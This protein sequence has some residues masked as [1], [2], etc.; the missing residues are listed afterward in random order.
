MRSI[1][2]ARWYSSLQ[3]N[4]VQKSPFAFV[5]STGTWQGQLAGEGGGLFGDPV[6]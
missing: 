1:A 4:D 6:E 5:Q 3:V 2:N